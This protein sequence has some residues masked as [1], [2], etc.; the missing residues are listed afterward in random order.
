MLF[1]DA[2]CFLLGFAW[3]GFMFISAKSGT[4]LGAEVAFNA[5]VKPYVLADLVKIA[6]AAAIVP[7]V[8]NLLRK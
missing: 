3:L 2:L 5:G 6:I 1:A 7:A 8:G 4:T